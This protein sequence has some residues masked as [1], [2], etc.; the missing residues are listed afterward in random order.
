M[1]SKNLKAIAVRG[2]KAVE[3]NNPPAGGYPVEFSMKDRE[4]LLRLAKHFST[5]FKEESPDN[6]GLN[7]LGTGPICYRAK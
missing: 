7:D 3:V 2:Y 4:T 1:G 6:A 5:N